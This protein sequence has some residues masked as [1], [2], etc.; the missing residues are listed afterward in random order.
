[1]KFAAYV[2]FC[3]GPFCFFKSAYLSLLS[4]QEVANKIL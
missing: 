1:M 2:M 4:K 3:F